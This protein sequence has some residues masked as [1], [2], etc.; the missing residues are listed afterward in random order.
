[1]ST[2]LVETGLYSVNPTTLFAF[3]VKFIVLTANRYIL[4]SSC[5][6]VK[7]ITTAALMQ[8]AASSAV[9][10]MSITFITFLLLFYDL[11]RRRRKLFSLLTMIQGIPGTEV[12]N[13]VDP[14]P[15]CGLTAESVI[16]K[17]W[18]NE[19]LNPEKNMKTLAT[20]YDFWQIFS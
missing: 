6:V 10:P 15:G 9:Q 13:S 5:N 16:L 12:Y 2:R 18:I 7:N 11:R 8:W 4:R 3:Y 1:M 14:G 19:H 17:N 20:C